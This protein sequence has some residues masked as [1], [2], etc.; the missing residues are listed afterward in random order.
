[1]T[2]Q[3]IIFLRIDPYSIKETSDEDKKKYQQRDYCLIQY[4]I[5]QINIIRFV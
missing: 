2:D 4:Q 5:L 1:M 3:D